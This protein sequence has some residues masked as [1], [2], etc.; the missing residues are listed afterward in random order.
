MVFGFVPIS[1]MLTRHRKISW[2]Y[3]RLIFSCILLS[4]PASIITDFVG[5]KWH[6]WEYSYDKTLHIFYFGSLFELI[7]WGV[8]FALAIGLIVAVF[9]EKEEKKKP[10]KPFF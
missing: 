10:F 7:L 8:L 3:R 2:K 6:T 9:A 5:L 1:F 4:I